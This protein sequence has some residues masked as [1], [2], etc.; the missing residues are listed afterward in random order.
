MLQIKRERGS[1][2]DGGREKARQREAARDVGMEGEREGWR[3]REPTDAV[4]HALVRCASEEGF[5][6]ILDTRGYYQAAPY[7]CNYA[8]RG[9][10]VGALYLR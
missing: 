8:S 3:E 6:L 2:R 9:E 7:L 10:C 4:C 1:E 5:S